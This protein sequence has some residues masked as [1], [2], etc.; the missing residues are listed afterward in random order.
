[1]EH[2]CSTGEQ[3]NPFSG[4]GAIVGRVSSPTVPQ[5]QV[6]GARARTRK[7]I[8]D[9]A[10]SVLARDRT[11][12]LAEI[13][14]AAEVGRTTLHRYFPDRGTLLGALTTDSLDAIH[15]AVVDAAVDEGPALDA[16][17]RLVAG[18]VAVGDRMLYLFNDPNYVDYSA[19][20]ED[21]ED[22]LAMSRF[23]VRAQQEGVLDPH[24]SP[25]WIATV[26]WTMAYT[27][28]MAVQ[29]GTLPRHGVAQAVTRTLEGGILA[30][31]DRHSGG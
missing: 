27:G 18:L 19:E 2:I 7:A 12:T 16:L 26:I 25:S 21:D 10:A 30:G 4:A 14:A 22:D 8:L 24:A 23:I 9:A 5:P 15:R 13:A 29:D 28:A 17:R 11:A 31:G 6:T 1:M 3:T 20:D